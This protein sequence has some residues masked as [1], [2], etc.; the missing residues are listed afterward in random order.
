[1]RYATIIAGGSGTRL[2]PMSRGGKPKQLIP[3]FAGRSLLELAA[4]RLKGL[5]PPERQFLCTGEQYRGQIHRVL[6]D[7]TDARI[8]GEPEGRDTLAA[9]GFP[10]ALAIRD[11]PDA[12]IGVL[13]ADHLIEPVE[14]FQR[15]VEV[16]F[17]VVE[18]HPDTLVTFG[19]PPTYA[20]TG[21]GYVELGEAMEGFDRVY[22]TVRFVEKPDAE[23]AEGYLASGRY[24]WNSGMFVWRAATLLAC[25]QR[26]KPEVY[27]G[28]MR[29][30][31]AWGT[32]R[33]QDV[34]VE[35]Y[36]RLEKISVDFA[37]M[38]PAS[39]DAAVAVAAV[40]MPLRWL[41]LG[42]WTAYGETLG[43][44]AEGNRLGGGRAVLLDSR[45]NLVVSEDP[46]H[47][48]ATV[49][50]DDLVV[51]HTPEVTMICRRDQAQRV[52]ELHQ[53]AEKA[54]GKEPRPG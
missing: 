48:I 20:A 32:P 46:N 44:D 10:A 29:I 23:T 3:L 5:I 4:D 35:V 27:A 28:L 1:M 19:I 42:S 50:V 51:V 53:A 39:T 45:N 17:Q 43:A 18:R 33:Q 24:A 47:L 37:V 12:V 15:R 34:L 31:A 30:A 21:F 49:G 25:I 16:G 7:F 52:K 54:A 14:D 41:D 8:L 9:V 2:W 40:A 22:R 11:D 36:P 13:T 6:P 38:E 26:Y